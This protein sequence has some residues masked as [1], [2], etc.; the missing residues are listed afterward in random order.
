LS[1][2]TLAQEFVDW[3]I[4]G[5]SVSSSVTGS[6]PLSLVH[7]LLEKS[8]KHLY[9]VVGKLNG[10]LYSDRFAE[11]LQERFAKNKNYRA[12]IICNK[13]KTPHETRVMLQ[14]QNEAILRL[15][16]TN[17]QQL[18]LYCAKD[19]PRKHFILID[20]HLLF[21]ERH[22]PGVTH[23]VFIK[24]GNKKLND[25]HREYFKDLVTNL[26][27]VTLLTPGDEPNSENTIVDSGQSR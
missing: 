26:E 7:D 20:D 5:S 19:R 3:K 18:K 9:V 4:L 24:S 14:S 11:I 6:Y 1:L 27:Y 8:S 22:A 13:G 23:A 16:D 12:H 17:S 10:N 25:D 2:A 21:E 15:F